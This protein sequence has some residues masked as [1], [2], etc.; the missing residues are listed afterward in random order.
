MINTCQQCLTGPATHELHSLGNGGF[1]NPGVCLQAFPSFP[2]TTPSYLFWALTPTSREQNTILVPFLGLSLLS[3][4]TETLAMQATMKYNYVL[5]D[6]LYHGLLS[7][8]VVQSGLKLWCV[9]G[10]MMANNFFQNW[11]L[12]N[13]W[14]ERLKLL[15][16]V[17]ISHVI[18]IKNH[19]HSM[20]KAKN[21]RYDRWLMY[22]Q[23]RQESGP[24]CFWFARRKVTETS[25]TEFCYWNEMFLL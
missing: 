6:R 14:I 25:V 24:C 13:L 21:L 16:S 11:I 20:K 2:S 23:P 5:F 10:N 12:H 7:R 1:Q 15:F 9:Y 17:F 3:N 4:P 19:N 8:R 18:K 22:K